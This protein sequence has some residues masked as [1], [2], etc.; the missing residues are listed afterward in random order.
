MTPEALLQSAAGLRR[1]AD[2]LAQALTDFRA[3]PAYQRVSRGALRGVTLERANALADRVCA[4]FEAL[5]SAYTSLTNADAAIVAGQGIFGKADK[6]R[7]AEEL[8]RRVALDDVD[9]GLRQ[10]QAAL[11]AIEDSREQLARKFDAAKADVTA[12]R[13]EVLP[14]QLDLIAA[15]LEALD[16]DGDPVGALQA[17]PDSVESPLSKLKQPFEEAARLR[18]ESAHALHAAAGLFSQIESTI[19]EAQA[20]YAEALEKTAGVTTIE[21][22]GGSS[23][24]ALG[25]WLSTLQTKAREGLAKPVL[26]GLEHWTVKARSLLG[27]GQAALQASRAPVQARREL[28]GLMQALKAKAVARGAA[29]NPRLTELAEQAAALLYAKP[30]PMP[31][32]AELVREYERLLN[33]R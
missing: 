5:E 4:L 23:I 26:I 27:E 22:P 18:K 20:A 2:A 1:T 13:E 19:R 15:K 29:E 32:A 17:F 30:T 12:L 8:L 11:A 33:G 6:L 16:L 25:E 3:L 14:D 21:P 10:S 24:Q 31:R 7:E 9:A 28:R